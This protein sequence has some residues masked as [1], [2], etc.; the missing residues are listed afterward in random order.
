MSEAQ[1]QRH[2]KVLLIPVPASIEDRGGV[3]GLLQV[4]MPAEARHEF[5]RGIAPGVVAQMHEAG[6]SPQQ[7]RWVIGQDPSAQWAVDTLAQAGVEMPR[8]RDGEPLSRMCQLPQWR[9]RG[10]GLL[11]GQHRHHG[12]TTEQLDLLGRES[13]GA[14]AARIEA[15]VH[16]WRYAMHQWPVPLSVILADEPVLERVVELLTGRPSDVVRW[17]DLLNARRA[18]TFAGSPVRVEALPALREVQV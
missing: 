13:D 18:E 4:H 7:V 14:F 15:G 9:S 1:V 3:P 17:G 12:L 5:T 8:R 2:A 10:W 11:T 16:V 6:A